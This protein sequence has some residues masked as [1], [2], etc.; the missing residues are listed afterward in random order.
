MRAFR[1]AALGLALFL[2]LLELA[3][4]LA[5]PYLARSVPAYYYAQYMRALLRESDTLIW[6][7][8]PKA[9]AEITNSLGKNIPYRLNQLGWRGKEFTPLNQPANALVLG[10]S[11]SFGLGVAEGERFVS[12][13]EK[14]LPGI[15]VWSPAQMGYAPDQYLLLAQRWLTAFPWA[16]LVVQLSGNDLVDIAGHEWLRPNSATGIPA[17]L[18]PPAE[19]ALFSEY[20]AAWNVAAH[21]WLLKKQKQLSPEALQRGLERLLFSLKQTLLLAKERNVSVVLL[22]ASDWG[23]AA[24]GK[25]TAAAYHDGVRALAK[26]FSAPLV[27]M[28]G[29]ELLPYPDLH[30]TSASHKKAAEHLLTAL[31]AVGAKKK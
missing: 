31:K 24:Y 21:W 16:F 26:E 1:F 17:A 4:R 12:L 30:W 27:E 28:A 18:A 20:S 11:F 15:S 25:D 22:Q 5:Q 10:D 2:A 23:E 29:A 6:E 13:L 19:H 14:S 3:A 8:V 9:Q 7:G